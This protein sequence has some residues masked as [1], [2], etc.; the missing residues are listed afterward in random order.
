MD[1]KAFHFDRSDVIVTK[2]VE[3]FTRTASGKSFRSKPLEV[4]EELITPKQYE[5]YVTAIPFFNSY[6]YGASCRAVLGY[7]KCGYIPT[8]IT[9]V[10]PGREV[11]L[12]ATFRFDFIGE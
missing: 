5:N 12:V 1:Y 9:S 8:R 7:T 4:T 6:G 2:K 3:K 10:S 11:K